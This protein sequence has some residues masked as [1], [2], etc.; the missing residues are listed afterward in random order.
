MGKSRE[1]DKIKICKSLDVISVRLFV[2]RNPPE[3]ITV[4]ARL[5]ES[6]SLIL[7]KLY[8]KIIKIVERKQI[9]N[10]LIKL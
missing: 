10:I 5:N 7:N 1:I 8:K 4:K 2:E 3:D 6:K 9:K